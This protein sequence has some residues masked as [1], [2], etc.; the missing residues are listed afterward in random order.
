MKQQ[1]RKPT[2]NTGAVQAQ[3]LS[4]LEEIPEGLFPIIGIGSLGNPAL[5]IIVIG[6]EDI[7]F[8]IRV[9]H[10]TL[11]F[12]DDPP[13]A[14]HLN[15]QC[16]SD[17]TNLQIKEKEFSLVKKQRKSFVHNVKS[18]EPFEKQESFR[19]F[20]FDIEATEP[21]A[22]LLDKRGKRVHIS[23]KQ[24]HTIITQ[25]PGYR[26]PSDPD[27]EPVIRVVIGNS[28]GVFVLEIPQP[29]FDALFRET[30]D[31]GESHDLFF[32]ANNSGLY[33]PEL[34]P[35]LKDEKD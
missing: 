17:A 23:A 6:G 20:D 30:L 12:G 3:Y 13:E 33:Y 9:S 1:E 19:R 27:M 11:D 14:F 24:T 29:L 25:L 22:F 18:H 15:I 7:L 4:L 8:I 31:D 10:G 2:T 16:K 26:K 32:P 34:V 28:D 35:K 5:Y 21:V